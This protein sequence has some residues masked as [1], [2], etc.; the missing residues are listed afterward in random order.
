MLHSPQFTKRSEYYDFIVLTFCS[1]C[2]PN[3]I[4]KENVHKYVSSCWRRGNAKPWHILRGI[5]A[6]VWTAHRG[7]HTASCVCEGMCVCATSDPRHYQQDLS[8][9]Q[10]SAFSFNPASSPQTRVMKIPPRS[11]LVLTTARTS[12]NQFFFKEPSDTHAHT[13]KAWSWGPDWRI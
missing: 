2:S 11:R 8:L 4:V 13:H 12:T 7:T 5:Q 1:Q 3:T 9:R 10:R 6:K